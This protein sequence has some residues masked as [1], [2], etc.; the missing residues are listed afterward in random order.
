MRLRP[1][2]H[3]QKDEKLTNRRFVSH[4][5]S[6]PKKIKNKKPAKLQRKREKQ[7]CLWNVGGEEYTC[8]G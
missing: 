5:P 6:P 3:K 1:P 4:A 8:A 2:Q 7:T